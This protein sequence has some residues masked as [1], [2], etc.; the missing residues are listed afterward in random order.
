[1]SG[2]TE[3]SERPVGI[4]GQMG[5][6]RPGKAPMG[7]RGGDFSKGSH[8]FADKEDGGYD[9]MGAVGMEQTPLSKNSRKPIWMRK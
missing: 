5:R 2:A 4:M 1:M 8:F 7:R 6:T 3:A 9:Y